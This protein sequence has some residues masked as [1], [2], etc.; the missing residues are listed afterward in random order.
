[1]S[2]ASEPWRPFVRTEAAAA[3][4]AS[5]VS[6]RALSS[7]LLVERTNSSIDSLASL[8][9]SDTDSGSVLKVVKMFLQSLGWFACAGSNRKH[10][11]RLSPLRWRGGQGRPRAEAAKSARSD[12]VSALSAAP[13]FPGR[14]GT[15]AERVLIDY[16]CSMR[17]GQA[18]GSGRLL[19]RPIPT[20]R[21]RGAAA[22]AVTSVYSREARY[23]A[24]RFRP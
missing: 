4:S 23:S 2:I 13:F 15:L 18:R 6:S 14:A 16:L 17:E 21:C 19:W 8:S 11:A 3:W 10:K 20:T 5:P 22:I 1:M 12:A 24:D 7:F 9:S